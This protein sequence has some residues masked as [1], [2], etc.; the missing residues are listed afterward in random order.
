MAPPVSR[1]ILTLVWI[2][3]AGCGS[4]KPVGPP[5]PESVTL[6]GGDNQ[7]GQVGLALAQLSVKVSSSRGVLPGARV[8]FTADPGHG[9]VLPSTVTTD[10]NGIAKATWT[11]GGTLGPQQARAA[12]ASLAPVVFHA[13]AAVGPPVL[14]SPTAGSVQFAVVGNPVPV[15]PRAW[16]TDAFGNAISG[17]QVVF[18]VSTGAGSI[19]DSVKT[20]DAGG[21]AELGSWTLGPGA[22]PN[23]VLAQSGNLT[24]QFFA[25]GTPAVVVES[26][27]NGQVI[28]AGTLAPVSPAVLA[29]DGGG[30]PLANVVVSFKIVAGEGKLLGQSVATGS[31]GIATVGGWILGV[32]PGP[33]EVVAEVTGTPQVQFTA[34]GVAAV[35]TTVAPLGSTM[36]SGLLGN[37]LGEI[38]AVLLT[39]AGGNP[40]AGQNVTYAVTQGAGAVAG[41][42]AVSD[43]MGRAAVGA[44]RLGPTDPLQL[45]TATTGAIAPVVFQATA[46]APP[47]AEFNIEVRFVNPPTA[48][49]QAAFDAAETRWEE[50]ILGDVADI[51]FM[52]GATSCNPTMNELVDDLV[53]FAELVEIDGIGG[54]LGSAGP[55]WI[56]VPGAIPLVGR[57]R[58]DTADLATLEADGRLA[59]VIMH[60][61]GHVLGFGTIWDNLDLLVGT[62]GSDPFFTGASARAAFAIAALPGTYPGESVPVE[63]TGGGGTRDSHWRELTFDAELMTG[64]IDQGSNPMS[65]VTTAS[66]RDLGYLVDD[67]RSDEYTLPAFLRAL[68]RAPFELREVPLPGP[69]YTISLSGR[70]MGEI[71]R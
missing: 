63:N 31:N 62:G 58:F 30:A 40:V 45:L 69:I 13:S 27:G 1:S 6:V 24:T 32:I 2:L 54:T 26:A 49:Q 29:L 3:V 50:V 37:F 8:T 41:A 16:L 70:P 55:C 18:H 48:G 7:N 33:N 4:D 44:W 52:Q 20:T 22:G 66:L 36:L 5:T 38:P 47:P 9:S 23:V 71:P 12:V 57:M 11:L 65:A 19:T 10:S 15:T 67:A 59:Q 53:I 56:R 46:S 61:M 21:F 25:T 43:F 60:E 35:A 51:P 28:N 17:A 14:L 68:G 34:T 64:F 42:A 39:D